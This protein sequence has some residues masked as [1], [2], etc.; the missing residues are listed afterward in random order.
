V[1]AGRKILN[2]LRFECPELPKSDPVQVTTIFERASAGSFAGSFCR[3]VKGFLT[4]Q[5]YVISA[6]F[7]V[8]FFLARN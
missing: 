8:K 4:F 2:V 5:F 7:R 3:I 1:N 6:K